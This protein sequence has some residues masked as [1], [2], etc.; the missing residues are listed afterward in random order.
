MKISLTKNTESKF[1]ESNPNQWWSSLGSV[2][3]HSLHEKRQETG[4]QTALEIPGDIAKGQ[5]SGHAKGSNIV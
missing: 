3:E 4:P 5:G 1:T 2:S